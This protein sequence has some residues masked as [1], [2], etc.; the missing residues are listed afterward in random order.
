M[1]HRPD[2]TAEGGKRKAFCLG[3]SFSRIEEMVSDAMAAIG[4]KKNG[5]STIED[6]V[7]VDILPRKGRREII[8]M[9]DERHARG[10][11]NHLRIIECAHDDHTGFYIA[12]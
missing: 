11:P 8:G 10:R 3:I 7:K 12:L 1:A 5:F 4:R 2:H 9:F 6:V